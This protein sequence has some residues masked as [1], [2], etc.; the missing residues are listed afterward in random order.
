MPAPLIGKYGRGGA[1]TA[2]PL[3]LGP[4]A[5]MQTGTRRGMG[6][7]NRAGRNTSTI[8]VARV[9]RLLQSR[10]CVTSECEKGTARLRM[11]KGPGERKGEVK[12]DWGR[13]WE[14]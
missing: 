13:E 6:H 12:G 4:P 10:Q 14:R 11:N 1:D 7:G 5:V 8:Q 3:E 9:P 2:S